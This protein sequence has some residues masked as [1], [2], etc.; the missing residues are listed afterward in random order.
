M[1]IRTWAPVGVVLCLSSFFALLATASC[2]GRQVP[3]T[4]VPTATPTP[5]PV[6]IVYA[7]SWLKPTIYGAATV[8]RDAQIR[9]LDVERD[10]KDNEGGFYYYEADEGCEFVRVELEVMNIGNRLSRIYVEDDMFSIRGTGVNGFD[11][12]CNGNPFRIGPS[13]EPFDDEIG[14]GQRV[15]GNFISEI[16]GE[17]TELRL[18]F[19]PNGPESETTIF[20][21]L[22]PDLTSSESVSLPGTPTP[23]LPPPPTPTTTPTPFPTP[24]ITNTPIATP[25][26]TH[27]PT[28]TNTPTVT[29]TATATKTVTATPTATNTPATVY[30]SSRSKPAIY[31]AAVVHLDLSEAVRRDIQIRVLDV[32][33]GWKDNEGGFYYYEADEGCEFIR[34]ELE[35]TNI[36]PASSIIYVEDDMFR[37]RGTGIRGWR[38][39]GDPFT[40]GPERDPF[41]GGVVAGNR[42]AGNFISQIPVNARNIRLE[43]DQNY[44]G[45]KATIFLSLEPDLTSGEL[46]SLPGTPTPT[47]LPTA[48][49]TMTQTPTVT[50]TPTITPTPTVTNS[51]TPVPIVYASSWSKPA[52]YGAAAMHRDTQMRVL[53]VE[54]DWKDR[55]YFYYEADGNC[56][57]IRVELE[58]MNIGDSLSRIYVEDDMFSIRGTGVN[59][60]SFDCNGNPFVIGPSIEPFDDEIG[61][62]QRVVGNFI[63]E[64]PSNAKDLRLEFAPNGPGTETTIFLSLEPD[65]TSD[66]SVSLPGTLTPTPTLTAT[67]IPTITPTSTVTPT[68]TITPTP[69]PSTPSGIT[70]EMYELMQQDMLNLVNTARGGNDL[71][72]STNQAAQNHAEDMRD[73]CYFSHDGLDGSDVSD[74]YSREG[75]R[76]WIIAENIHLHGSC[77]GGMKQGTLREL[78]AD[79]HLN[80][81]DSPGHRS[82]ILNSSFDEVAFGFAYKPGGLWVVQVFIG[83]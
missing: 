80:L 58:A 32:E 26:M 28:V 72:L 69:T 6:P 42:R 29:S 1:G 53:D 81:M 82:N 13:S 35:V 49:P 12:D 33:R 45:S 19:S 73:N 43:L 78:V 54:R 25:T 21:S 14:A 52:I 63:S 68:P 71:R 22:E 44:S 66:E 24:T 31:G 56:E 4:P 5:T 15:V 23:T 36:G 40:Y 38:C 20:L 64:I 51:P 60:F 83:K 18:E 48:T 75:G 34:V 61:A 50:N 47:P 67:P 65:Q 70:D 41:Y 59:S 17:A 37:I 2:T 77:Y 57:F 11:F 10:W 30:G 27:T 39:N 3:D 76:W 62:G 79:A 16:P 9:V 55:G 7:S 74:R 46:V 8:H